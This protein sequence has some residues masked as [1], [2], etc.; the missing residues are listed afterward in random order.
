[1]KR[2]GLVK[3]VLRGTAFLLCVLV[4]ASGIALLA[5]ISFTGGGRLYLNGVRILSAHH[6]LRMAL[7]SFLAVVVAGLVFDAEETRSFL[8]RLR[9]ESYIFLLL[10][11]L[12]FAKA[13]QGPLVIQG[14]AIDYVIQTQSLV[15]HRTLAVDPEEIRTIW[16]R[17]NPYDVTL[18]KVRYP[19]EAMKPLAGFGGL[20]RDRF[21]DFR[22]VH[23]WT[24]SLLVAPLYGVLHIS[25]LAPNLE[26]YSFRLINIFLLVCP[27]LIAWHRRGSWALL[28]VV[29]LSLL[30]PLIPYVDWQHTEIFSLS[31]VVISFQAATSKR[32]RFVSPM[33]LGL[34]ATQNIP[35]LFFFPLHFYHTFANRDKPPQKRLGRLFSPYLAGVLVA[36]IPWMYFKY[37][38]GV[39]NM[40]A[41]TGLADLK[42]A[43][44]TRTLDLFINPLTGALWFFPAV[45]LFPFAGVDKRK[46]PWLFGAWISIF[47]AAYL[48][49]S[50]SNFSAGQ[51]GSSRYTVWLLAP[52]FFFILDVDWICQFRRRLSS[53]VIFLLCT[54]LTI[55]TIRYFGTHRLFEKDLFHFLSNQ[56]AITSTGWLAETLDYYGDI[57]VLA[58]NIQGREIS[59]PRLFRDIYIWNT[60]KARSVWIIPRRALQ[61]LDSFQWEIDEIPK[62][63]A[64]PPGN[65]LS[66]KGKY[67]VID[68]EG[69]KAFNRHP[70]L[71]EYVF[72]KVNK[73][74]NQVDSN[75][76]THIAPIY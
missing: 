44:V 45:I 6:P 74:V 23:A 2:Q 47:A 37:Y 17:G 16:N 40:I 31:L 72:L 66:R 9:P 20:Y 34:A 64:Q 13:I 27:L 39:F 65:L 73:S 43:S 70:V 48:S 35:I 5:W 12:V 30:S 10:F 67:V 33:L 71:G 54:L 18:S 63:V 7:L 53:L 26:H 49:T 59:S 19:R 1:M 15:M 68:P 55:G 8:R 42:Y 21:D 11:L 62:Y 76:R 41:S 58:E 22:Y 32:W 50:T 56:R 69:A 52:F 3:G 61:A 25:Q 4:C 60:D 51:V 36:V 75:V 24:Y 29:L 14:D 38:F 46:A 28:L 57:E